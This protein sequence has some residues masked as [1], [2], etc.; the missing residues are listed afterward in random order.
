MTLQERLDTLLAE[1]FVPTNKLVTI[2]TIRDECGFTPEQYGLVRGTL[3]GAIATLKADTDPVKRLQGIELQ[4]ALTAMLSGGI[5][6]GE[7]RKATID[8]LAQFGQWPDSVRD[9]VKALGGVTQ[10]QWQVEGYE[11]EPTLES[12]QAEID[13]ETITAIWAAKQAVVSEG[14]FNGT[15]TTLADIVAAIGGE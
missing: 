10:K 11:S 7:T 2:G 14:I 12:V 8:L 13:R 15:I 6:L 5:P 3:D 1:V 9:T 4:D